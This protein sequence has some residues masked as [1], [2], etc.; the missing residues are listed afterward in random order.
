M[1]VGT[2][3]GIGVGLSDGTGVVCVGVGVSETIGVTV[4]TFDGEGVGGIGV[5]LSE[6]VQ[7][8]VA[9]PAGP[10]DPQLLTAKTSHVYVSPATG[11]KLI[12][13]AGASISPSSTIVSGVVIL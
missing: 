10:E 12:L 8:W 4:G 6:I 3:L 2:L 1:L 11:V 13:V 9:W 7:V 5:G